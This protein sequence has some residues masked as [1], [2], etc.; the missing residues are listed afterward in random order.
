MYSHSRFRNEYPVTT[1]VPSCGQPKAAYNHPLKGGEIMS[2][3]WHPR[4]GRLR[5]TRVYAVIGLA[6][7]FGLLVARD[8]PPEFPKAAPPQ[9]SATSAVSFISAVLSHDQRPRF[10]CSGLQWSAP[11][12]AFL[13]FPPAETS[14]HL[15]SPSQI[16]PGLH[17]KGLHFNR[18]P[19][20]A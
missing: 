3:A 4:R 19:P 20:L 16:F 6:A 8:I 9:H 2:L 12:N 17:V 15:T 14:S 7:L 11:I 13:P 18:P 5:A 1:P 10:D